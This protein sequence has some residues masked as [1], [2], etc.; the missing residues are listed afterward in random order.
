M[1]K[2]DVTVGSDDP[3]GLV[4][5]V[6]GDVDMGAAEAL[7]HRLTPICAR[8]PPLVVLD[9]SGVGFIGSL[10]LGSLVTFHRALERCGGRVRVA[11]V[12]PRVWEVFTRAR[13][14]SLFEHFDTVDAALAAPVA[15]ATAG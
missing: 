4:V 14:Q 2:V 10:G 11:A 9:L 7:G 13:L 8:R 15:T 1:S 3:R 5:R 12:Q 6:A